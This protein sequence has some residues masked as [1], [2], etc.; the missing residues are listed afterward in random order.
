MDSEDKSEMHLA[1]IPNELMF[2]CVLHLYGFVMK[3]TT[4][5]RRLPSYFSTTSEVE[6]AK[7]PRRPTCPP[8]S[9][10]ARV[11]LQLVK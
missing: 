9:S 2:A 11:A 4:S 6:A 8:A 10:S 3:N 5:D 7:S 1:S